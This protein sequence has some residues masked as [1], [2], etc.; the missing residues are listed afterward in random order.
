MLYDVQQLLNT[1]HGR[2]TS[3]QVAD[4]FGISKP[5]ASSIMSTYAKKGYLEIIRKEH[6]GGNPRAVYTV[7]QGWINRINK[8][9]ESLD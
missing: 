1:L 7:G 5:Q 3:A 9:S 2:I 4:K 8:E 6:S